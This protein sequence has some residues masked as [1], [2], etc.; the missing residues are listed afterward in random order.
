MN[1]LIKLTSIVALVIAPH[2]NEG[3]AHP[4][5][6][7]HEHHDHSHGTVVSPAGEPVAE[8]STLDVSERF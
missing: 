1:I 2:I 4:A 7:G 3:E 8:A 6:P 5:M